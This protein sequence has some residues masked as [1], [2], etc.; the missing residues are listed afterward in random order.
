[1]S[2][3]IVK[4]CICFT[5]NCQCIRAH[6]ACCNFK[7]IPYY[8]VKNAYLLLPNVVPGLPLQWLLG[9]VHLPVVW[10]KEVQEHPTVFMIISLRK[11]QQAE[12]RKGHFCWCGMYMW[13]CLS[14][15][16]AQ[17]SINNI[18]KRGNL[19][20]LFWSVT[21]KKVTS[22]TAHAELLFKLSFTTTSKI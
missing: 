22:H 14:C 7:K 20:I 10:C 8:I 4:L 17:C 6:T 11:Y 12:F 3:Y 21:N 19:Q 9:Q 5:W 13:I 16:W 18:Y 2:R 15:N 1:M